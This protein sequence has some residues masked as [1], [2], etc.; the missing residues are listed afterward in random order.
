MILYTPFSRAESLVDD[1]KANLYAMNPL[2]II[3]PG[4]S[5]METQY[6]ND[7]GT[8]MRT[9]QPRYGW[10]YPKCSVKTCSAKDD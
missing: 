8:S 4:M 9:G 3:C 10:H 7:H 2:S 6:A 1:V 5:A